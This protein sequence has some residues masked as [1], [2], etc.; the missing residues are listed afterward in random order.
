ME[1]TY[2]AKTT[3]EKEQSCRTNTSDFKIYY[4]FLII[5]TV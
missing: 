2:V 3:L 1:R 4:K 5:K